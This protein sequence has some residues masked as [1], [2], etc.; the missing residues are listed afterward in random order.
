MKHL[1]D[2]QLCACIP[3]H[4]VHNGQCDMPVSYIWEVMIQV[5]FELEVL[6]PELKR[7]DTSTWSR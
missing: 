2:T 7:D 6:L 4:L 1:P 5:T 3:E